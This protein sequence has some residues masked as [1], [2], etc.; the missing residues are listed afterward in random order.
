MQRYYDQ[1]KKLQEEYNQ[2]VLEWYRN[3]D[4]EKL[5]VIKQYFKAKG[6]RM[7]G[8]PA[9]KYRPSNVYAV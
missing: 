2:A 6:R 5:K 4:R 7:P 8:N 9:M 3:V 1:S